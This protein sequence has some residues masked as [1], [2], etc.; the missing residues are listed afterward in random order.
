[1]RNDARQVK[2][3]DNIRCRIEQSPV[4]FQGPSSGFGKILRASYTL[5]MRSTIIYLSWLVLNRK[6]D[7]NFFYALYSEAFMSKAFL[8]MRRKLFYNFRLP[9]SYSIYSLVEVF[10]DQL[11]FVLVSCKS[12]IYS[13][14]TQSASLRQ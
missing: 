14:A 10:K 8:E 4:A 1:M 12:I 6:H 2:L 7:W 11:P 13:W 3:T 9:S 5:L